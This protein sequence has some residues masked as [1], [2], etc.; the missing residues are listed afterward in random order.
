[1]R[2]TRWT[3]IA[4]LTS[5]LLLPMSLVQAATATIPLTKIEVA[6][7]QASLQRGAMIYY[8]E[9]RMCHSLKYIKYRHLLDIGFDQAFVDQLR[10][11]RL[12]GERL[13]SL[14]NDK[15]ITA[16]FGMVPPELSL[17]AK[18][19]PHGPDYIYTLMTSYHKTEDGHY[20]NHLF[21]NIKMPDVFDISTAVDEQEK[22]EISAKAKDVV[23]FLN[24]TADPRAQERKSLGVWV[25]GYFVIFTALY[26]LLMKRVWRQ[27]KPG[28]S[29]N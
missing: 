15:V 5:S 12:M 7:D 10:G 24:W 9:C 2:L 17:M 19:R 6:T 25:I 14:N 8:N 21:P 18:A 23:A 26:Y 3:S 20:N 16:L 11:E 22:S 4:A 27:V 13:V 1:M 28:L 29:S